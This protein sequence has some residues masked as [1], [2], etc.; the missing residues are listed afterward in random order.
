MQRQARSRTS[1]K[2]N[3]AKARRAK[4]EGWRR[5]LRKQQLNKAHNVVDRV[6][7]AAT[8]LRV[9][10]L[11]R[12]D[13]S[14]TPPH[15]ALSSP[16]PGVPEDGVLVVPP[17][18]SPGVTGAGAGAGAGSGAM[19]KTPAASPQDGARGDVDMS[20]VRAKLLFSPPPGVAP[21][22]GEP[23]MGGA[24]PGGSPLG[25]PLPACDDAVADIDPVMPLREAI[26]ALLEELYPDVPD[27]ANVAPGEMEEG[28]D[29]PFDMCDSDNESSDVSERDAV[30]TVLESKLPAAIFRRRRHS[31]DI[32][33]TGPGAGGMH[34]RSAS[35]GALSSMGAVRSPTHRRRK[36]RTL[37][38]CS[39]GAAS[40]GTSE[41]M[42]DEKVALSQV[43]SVLF[44]RVL[45]RA[46]AKVRYEDPRVPSL[47][48]KLLCRVFHSCPPARMHLC[49]SLAETTF[50]YMDIFLQELKAASDPRTRHHALPQ[51]A[52]SKPRPS[53]CGDGSVLADLLGTFT[54][55]VV[56][57]CRNVAPTSL[58]ADV[59]L[60]TSQAE[61]LSRA[62]IHLCRARPTLDSHYE[63]L[64]HCMQSLIS[65]RPT[66]ANTM[67]RRLLSSW[68]RLDGTRE[69]T[70]VL[71]VQH[72]VLCCPAPA[73]C[74]SKLHRPVMRRIIKAL[75]SLHAAVARQALEL[76]SNMYFML[77]YVLPYEDLAKDV[78]TT[79]VA[80]RAHWNHVVVE[81]SDQSFENMLDLC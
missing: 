14:A 6:K 51:H 68:P 28:V 3:R 41:A 47:R 37:S 75:G 34:T 78:R 4:S 49:R 53:R 52:P 12:R 54:E 64:V 9:R 62:V 17:L 15:V 44:Q 77:H 67:L 56:E 25:S 13:E 29:N 46:I 31:V 63:L 20:P 16:L 71:L 60:L 33:F 36:P 76:V 57:A 7:D 50:D 23:E 40:A 35:S 79:L 59:E 27:V 45:T 1:R 48:A 70:W 61:L 18:A 58:Q 66:L 43:Q 38:V 55:V 39:E 42:L 69:V 5:R 11:R 24:M 30:R 80:N 26:D 74:S 21:G 81:M 22:G 19:Y 65:V 8:D 2:R 73:V 32:H 10:H 72:V